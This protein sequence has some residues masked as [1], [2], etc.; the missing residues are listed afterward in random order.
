M[1][2]RQ[3]HECG[4]GWMEVCQNQTSVGYQYDG[5]FA[6]YMVVPLSLIHI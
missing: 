4:K 1:Y 2:K 5:G 6:E 3:C